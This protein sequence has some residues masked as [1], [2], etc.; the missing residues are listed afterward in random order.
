MLEKFG[1]NVSSLYISQ[2]KTK[3]GII[4]RENYNKGKEGHRVPQCPKEKEEAIM[5][6]LR[7]FR[8]I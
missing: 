7:N 3:S 2:V 5:D 4:E 8:M 6:A 1:L